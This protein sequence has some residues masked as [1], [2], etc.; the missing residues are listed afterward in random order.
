[1]SIYQWGGTLLSGLTTSETLDANKQVSDAEVAEKEAKKAF[2]IIKKYV[3]HKVNQAEE[4]IRS[5]AATIL[6]KIKEKNDEIAGLKQQLVL[7]QQRDDERI[8]Q[9]QEFLQQKLNL[10]KEENIIKMRINSFQATLNEVQTEKENLETAHHAHQLLDP[11][12]YEKCPVCLV[13]I[14]NDPSFKC[15]R[16]A[17]DQE[18]SN[19]ALETMQIILFN[20]RQDLVQSINELNHTLE[21]L[22][23]RISEINSK[24]DELNLEISDD[25]SE[26]LSKIDLNEKEQKELNEKLIGLRQDLE[27]FRDHEEYKRKHG[28]AKDQLAIA[29]S[30]RNRV[31]QQMEDNIDNLKKYF[32]EVVSYL[33]FENRIGSF[34][35]SER[36]KNFEVEIRYLN[37]GEGKDTGA[38]AITLAVIAYDLALLK[39]AL[40]VDTPH[41]RLLVHDSPNIN[42]IDPSVYNRIFTYVKDTLEKSFTDQGLEPEFQYIITTILMPEELATDPYIRLELN[43]NGDE[44]KL[45]EFTF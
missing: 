24:I 42:D 1:M 33:Y 21:E 22:Q 6:E 45:F 39:L 27:Y 19:K 23:L 35:L 7:L 32:H 20:E 44:G 26:I 14:T 18:D 17:E 15:P 38:A 3:H 28:L 37:L 16:S 2:D 10:S 31:Q 41:P 30:N 36:A 5:E 12:E 40:K 25:A 8:T 11:Y 29:K 13:T 9:K 4:L 34:Q 43:N